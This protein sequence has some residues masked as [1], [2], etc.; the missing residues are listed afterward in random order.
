MAEI[1]AV[2]INA[3]PYLVVLIYGQLTKLAR[4]S[5]GSTR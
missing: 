3:D 4:D 5:K 1:D 2:S